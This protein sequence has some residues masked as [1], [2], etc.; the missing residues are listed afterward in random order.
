MSHIDSE[1][2][3]IYLRHDTAAELSVIVLQR[4]HQSA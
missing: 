4:Q 3:K 1:E 2:A